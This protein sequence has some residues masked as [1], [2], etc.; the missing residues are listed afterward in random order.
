MSVKDASEFISSTF[1]ISKKTVYN[2]GIKI[3]QEG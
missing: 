1:D 3:K 2:I